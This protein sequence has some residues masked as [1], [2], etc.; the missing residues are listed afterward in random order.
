MLSK[1]APVKRFIL[2]AAAVLVGWYWWRGRNS[3][4]A[5]DPATVPGEGDPISTGCGPTINLIPGL[6]S[7]G[8]PSTNGMSSTPAPTLE[9]KVAQANDSWIWTGGTDPGKIVTAGQFDSW[10]S[11]YGNSK[12]DGNCSDIGRRCLLGY[13]CQPGEPGYK[14]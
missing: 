4:G 8:S 11:K 10:Y 6:G 3:S 1:G 5:V 12:C 14:G 9:Q 2:F 7:V 13:D